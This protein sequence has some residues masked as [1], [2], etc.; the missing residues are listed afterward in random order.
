MCWV[1][2]SDYD[3]CT[4]LHAAFLDRLWDTTPIIDR[5]GHNGGVQ[6]E[7][8]SLADTLG[9]WDDLLRSSNTSRCFIDMLTD[10]LD[11]FV[12]QPLPDHL[13]AA[14]LDILLRYAAIVV[15]QK[16][17]KLVELTV[18]YHVLVTNVGEVY[19]IS[20]RVNPLDG[21]CDNVGL[22]VEILDCGGVCALSEFCGR[23]SFEVGGSRWYS[24]MRGHGDGF[25]GIGLVVP[26]GSL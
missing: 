22:E 20:A 10:R 25:V 16:I 26:N 1:F 6:D 18:N 21:G 14:R 8:D 13:H 11:R 15:V 17:S 12:E 3:D 4:P 2:D 24:R 19:V 9:F 23:M 5:V 7:C